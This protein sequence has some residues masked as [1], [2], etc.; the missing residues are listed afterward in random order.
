MSDSRTPITF[1]D[2]LNAK[3]IE[4]A[5]HRCVVAQQMGRQ[6][7]A[8]TGYRAALAKDAKLLKALEAMAEV[9]GKMQD[10][11][12]GR[13]MRS[14]DAEFGHTRGTTEH[15]LCREAYRLADEGR[16]IRNFEW[17]YG[18]AAWLCGYNS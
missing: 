11:Q 13:T 1:D 16:P 6:G 15:Q 2:L 12:M 18:A 5:Y 4:E 10:D 17:I 7:F 9:T 8:D 3:R 14:P